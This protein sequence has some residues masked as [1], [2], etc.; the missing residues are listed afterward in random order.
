M[1]SSIMSAVPASMLEL[2]RAKRSGGLRVFKEARLKLWLRCFFRLRPFPGRWRDALANVNRLDR[3]CT[4]LN[5]I[6][7]A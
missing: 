3:P 1:I 2:P 5:S 4:Y 6:P 7:L